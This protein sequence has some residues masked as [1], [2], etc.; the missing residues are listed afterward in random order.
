MEPPPP[1]T[2][3]DRLLRLYPTAKRQTLRRMIQ[4]GRVS[5]NG[6]RPE[7]LRQVLAA[8]DV[9]DVTDRVPVA[10]SRT[11]SGRGDARAAAGRRATGLTILYEDEDVLVVNKPAGLLT[12]T[13]PREPRP[14]LLAAV[15]EHV[16][17]REP[18]ARVGLIHRL[19]RDASGLLVFSKNDAA[20]RSLKHQFFEHSVE[21][22]YWAVVR[23]RPNPPHGRIETRLVERADGTVRSTR[24]F[25]K[26]EQAVTD[27]EVARS[28]RGRSLMRVTLQ[29]GRKHQIRVHLRERGNPILGDKV[30]GSETDR[31]PRLMLTAAVLS[32]THPRTGERMRFEGPIPPEFPLNP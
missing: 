14:T 29:T 11:T 12:S 25:G 26:G 5:V 10:Q 22:V 1:E 32:F 16:A 31:E 24:Q 6:R 15:R 8:A 13:V 7:G 21:R 19:D 30:Y 20:Y 17:E 28:E 23:G 2:L 27:Y 3:L 9:I 4:A 18:R